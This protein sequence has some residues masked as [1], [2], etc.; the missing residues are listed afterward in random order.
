MPR[1]ERQLADHAHRWTG[2]YR[3]ACLAHA[4]G[5]QSD[6]LLD[7]RMACLERSRAALTA[8]ADLVRTADAKALP[9][10]VTATQALPDP[11]GCGDLASLLANAAPPPAAIAARVADIRGRLAAV[12]IQIAAGQQKRARAAA[13]EAVT[14]ARGLDYRPLLAEALLV[15]GQATM[16]T[17]DRAA[18]TKPLTE[19]FT[20]AFE[21]GDQTM[22]VEAWARRAWTHGLS[23]GGPESLAG[24]DVV[25]AAAGNGSVSPFARALLYNNVGAVEIALEQ[26]DRA[27]AA[28]ERALRE[29]RGVVG[30]GAAELLI[31]RANLG[32][33]TD[34]PDRRDQIL[35]DAEAEKAR[36]LGADHPATLDTRWLRGRAMVSF[37]RAAEVLT[38]ACAGLEPYDGIQAMSCW[39][40]L[41]HVRYELSDKAGAIAAM[42]RALTAP[43]E[44]APR[45]PAILPYLH[46][47]QGDAG[48]AAKEFAAALAALP[49]RDDAPWWMR[50]ERAE[51]Q[52]GL[53]RAHRAG[54]R[55]R[56]AK[57]AL[58]ACLEA[59]LDIAS[60]QSDGVVDRRLGRTRAELAEVLAMLRAPSD[61]IAV[62]AAPA[63]AWMRRA[64]G[65][66][67]EILELDRLAGES[68]P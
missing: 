55:L 8:V 12:R 40:E 52:L 49:V 13:A 3:D 25:E 14:D 26:R 16:G 39:S 21:S 20:L 67:Q 24:L 42:Q 44:A 53:A 31:V 35:A 68:T 64:G 33:T 57:Q 58:L 50:S 1:L 11:D 38:G 6:A 63:A 30:P 34:D 48:A 60:K 10:L 28:F 56:E 43:I 65:S 47:W 37:A 15:L 17:D 51:L 19:A 46:L 45:S 29:A 23:G 22:A 5:V 4:N 9:D 32:I 62:Q 59:L 36:V 27:R 2:G 7:R 61:R 18:A 54:G 66:S 41:G